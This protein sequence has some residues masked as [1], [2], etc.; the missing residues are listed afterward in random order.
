MKDDY[1]TNSHYL[2]YTFLFKSLG[3]FNFFILGM[4]GLN[5]KPSVVQIKEPDTESLG[6]HIKKYF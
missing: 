6:F 5:V 3:E 2:T 4:E 1:T